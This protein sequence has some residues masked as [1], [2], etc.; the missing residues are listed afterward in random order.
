MSKSTAYYDGLVD[1]YLNGKCTPEQEKELWMFLSSSRSNRVLL[2]KMKQQFH[3]HA[4][5]PPLLDDGDRKRLL[6]R[7][8]RA[9]GQPEMIPGRNYTKLLKIAAVLVLAAGT[10]FFFINRIYNRS[11]A[12]TELVNADVLPGGNKG[13]MVLSSGTRVDFQALK[14]GDSV[15][16]DGLTIA[17]SGEGAIRVHSADGMAPVDTLSR[18]N[19][20]QT[21][22][23]GQYQVTLSDGT[24]VWMNAGSVLKFPAS[25]TETAR[26]VQ[27]EGELYFE[28][29]KDAARPFRVKTGAQLVEVL[30]T[31]FS[32]KS[33]ADNA[34]VKTTL[35]EGRIRISGGTA[36]A[37]ILKPG[38]VSEYQATTNELKI[39][40]YKN[41]EEATA[42][43]N[44]YFLFDSTDFI[45]IQEQLEKWYDVTFT[46]DQVPQMQFFGKVPRNV[47]LS[48]VL[49]LMEMVGAIKFKIEGRTIH[50]T[51]E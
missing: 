28:V 27:A 25:F 37:Q 4:E 11:G 47:P 6:N 40:S 15:K 2:K 50:V 26:L 22:V 9:I 34:V 39:M 38:E 19:T 42:W 3:L 1:L 17:K 44:G 10:A 20:I 30:G 35:L 24:I 23:G 29:A 46:Y 49:K 31:H 32:V 48:R 5:A 45:T 16:R 12:Q 43:K 18:M 8:I 51:T 13:F 36:H 7:V 33:N 41:P 14:V 21:P